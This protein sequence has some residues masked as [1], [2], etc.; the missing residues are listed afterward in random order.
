MIPSPTNPQS[1]SSGLNAHKRWSVSIPIPKP[2]LILAVLRPIQPP[3][4]DL[5]RN[6]LLTRAESDQGPTSRYRTP[7]LI[8]RLALP[9]TQRVNGNKN[10]DSEKIDGP[11][12]DAGAA[13]DRVG[14]A[15]TG[16]GAD[17]DEHA[18]PEEGVGAGVVDV[19]R[20]V[21]EWFVGVWSGGLLVCHCM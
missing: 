16:E 21:E 14:E 9:D 13:A 4:Q 20:R 2:G 19:R 10:Q 5:Q 11:E 7:V 15:G 3:L 18:G 6:N 17:E 12:E 8:D 1:T